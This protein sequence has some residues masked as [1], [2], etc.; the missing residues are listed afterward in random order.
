METATEAAMGRYLT[1]I[2]VEGNQGRTGG[3]DIVWDLRV[4]KN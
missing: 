3:S 1:H 4:H 2:L